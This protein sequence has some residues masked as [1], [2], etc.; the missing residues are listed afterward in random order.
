MKN[1]AKIKIDWVE[2]VSDEKENGD[3]LLYSY[4]RVIVKVEQ[5]GF[6]CLFAP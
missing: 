2:E 5:V 1:G 3:C 4:D 6:L